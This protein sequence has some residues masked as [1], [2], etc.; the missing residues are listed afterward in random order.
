M[1]LFKCEI[2]GNIVELLNDGGGTLVC[3][4]QEMNEIL[5]NEEENN[6]EKHLPYLKR[7]GNKVIVE[8]GETHHPM[9]E[10]HYIEWVALVEGNKVNKINLNPGDE[11]IVEFNVETDNFIVYAYCNIHGFYQTKSTK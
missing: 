3:C 5:I 2:C 1:K 8:V 7:D 11:P 10:E 6:Y 9:I 4:G